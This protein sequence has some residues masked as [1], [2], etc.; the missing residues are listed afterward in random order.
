MATQVP[1]RFEA[2]RH[3]RGGQFCSPACTGRS[4]QNRKQCPENLRPAQNTSAMPPVGQC[5]LMSGTHCKLGCKQDGDCPKTAFCG[6]M[7][8]GVGSCAYVI[9]DDDL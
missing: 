1:V 3:Q 9:P 7:N 6:D 5:L 4:V 8:F 2:T